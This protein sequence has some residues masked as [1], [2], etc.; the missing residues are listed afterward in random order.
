MLRA[1]CGVK[2]KFLIIMKNESLSVHT[3][4]NFLI[5]GAERIWPMKFGDSLL[6]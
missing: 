6:V 4:M 3:I 2:C 5:L 1:R